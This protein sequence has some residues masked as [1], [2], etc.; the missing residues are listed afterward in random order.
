MKR[1]LSDAV[2]IVFLLLLIIIA[3][4]I[5]WGVVKNSA[6]NLGETLSEPDSE[7]LESFNEYLEV[8]NW[9]SLDDPIKGKEA[10][11]IIAEIENEFDLGNGFSLEMTTG[12]VHYEDVVLNVPDSDG[13]D[14]KISYDSL[15]ASIE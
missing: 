5:T 7:D 12:N 2:I 3:G 4:G 9:I 1:D 14:L 13:P 8:Q 10:E 15:R 11:E 6:D